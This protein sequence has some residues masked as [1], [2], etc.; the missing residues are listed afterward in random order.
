[1]HFAMLIVRYC[2]LTVCRKNRQWYCWIGRC[3]LR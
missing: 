1:M 3:R 2:S